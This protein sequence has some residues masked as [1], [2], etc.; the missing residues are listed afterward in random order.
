MNLRRRRL[1]LPALLGIAILLVITGMVL[2]LQS[3]SVYLGLM[4]DSQDGQLLN[5]ARVI[6]KNISLQLETYMSELDYATSRRGFQT[7]EHEWL[8]TGDASGLLMRMEENLISQ[9]ELIHCMLIVQDGEIKLSTSGHLDYALA[10]TDEYHDDMI[11]ACR[12]FDGS[13]YLALLHQ[14]GDLTYAA[15]LDLSLYYS[16]IKQALP[17]ATDRVFLL[18]NGSNLLVHSH[19]GEIRIDDVPVLTAAECDES[20]LS[21][22]LESHK[23]GV[24]EA[25]SYVFTSDGGTESYTARLAVLPASQSNNHYFTLGLSVNY[26]AIIQPL[27]SQLLSMLL[28]TVM[29]MLGVLMLVLLAIVYAHGNRRAQREIALLHEKNTQMEQL[30]E[31]TLAL[32]HHQRLETLGTLTSKISHE[33]N[34]LLTPIMGHSILALESLPPECDDLRDNITEIYNASHAAKTV[35]A[36]LNELSRKNSGTANR[37]LSAEALV[38]KALAVAA[39]AKNDGIVVHTD[40][41]SAEGYV[42]GNETQ[43]SQL[44]LNLVLNAYQAMPGGGTLTAATRMEGGDIHIIIS[45]TGPGIPQKLHKQ[46]FEPFFTTKEAGKGTCLGLAI[47]QQVVTEHH[48]SIHVESAPGCGASFIVTLPASIPKKDPDED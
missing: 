45:D 32:Y 9:D 30:T 16:S 21:A 19:N 28:Y 36:R 1:A 47:A 42:Y 48:G 12:S 31:K 40:C 25:M 13:A 18:S 3:F 27:N 44:L 20:A 29:V 33:F 10:D 11:A 2:L 15:L 34:N 43:L 37:H 6:D 23:T 8:T 35:I 38:R 26:D 24:S 22:L 4:S 5:W 39:P 41:A 7:S 17:V 46:I 14:R